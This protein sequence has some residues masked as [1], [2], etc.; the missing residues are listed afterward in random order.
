MWRLALA[1]LVAMRL[2]LELVGLASA[3]LTPLGPPNGEWSALVGASGEPLALSIWQR[4]DALWYQHIAEDWYRPGD[5]TVH[6]LP[7]YPLL[8]RATSV[9]VRPTVLVQLVVSSAAFV[10]AAWL[11]VEVAR[12]DVGCEAAQLALLLAVA[13]PTGFFLFAPYTESLYLALSLGA[14]RLAR[15]ERP[16]L[17]GACGFAAGCTRTVG[18]LLVAPLAYAYL[19]KRDRP[20]AAL[21]AALGPGL[22]LALSTACLRLSTGEHRS[23]LE[24]AEPWGDRL[25]PPWQALL[26][27]WEFIRALGGDPPE[28]VNFVGLLGAIVLAVVVTRRLSLVYAVYVWPYLALVASRQS[29]AAPLESVARYLVVLFPLFVA[30]AGLLVRKPLLAMATLAVSLM[31]QVVLFERWVHFGFVG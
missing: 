8:V 13:F 16:W 25:S 21:L 18:A 5:G 28:L 19:E 26:A 1:A 9:I 31:L 23:M 10:V 20:G 4:W 17:A 2:G 29:A 7:L 3:N 24:V 11:L 27:S 22:G 30:L 14:F 12:L 15:A 6:F